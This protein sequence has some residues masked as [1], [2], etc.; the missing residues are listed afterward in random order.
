MSGLEMARWL[1][2]GT[3]GRDVFHR[4]GVANRIRQSLT[5][6]EHFERYGFYWTGPH[7]ERDLLIDCEAAFDS[8]EEE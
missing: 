8:T 3:S 1:A 7:S 2:Q 5:I 4:I 6:R